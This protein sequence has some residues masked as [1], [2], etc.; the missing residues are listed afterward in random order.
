MCL[1]SCMYVHINVSLYLTYLPLT[2]LQNLYIIQRICAPAGT[3]RAQVHTEFFFCLGGSGKMILKISREIIA[4]NQNYCA[5]CLKIVLFWL[6]KRIILIDTN[7]YRIKIKFSSR[8]S[9]FAKGGDNI[10][11]H[12][13]TYGRYCK[14]ASEIVSYLVRWMR[15][16]I[17]IIARYSFSAFAVPRYWDTDILQLYSKLLRDS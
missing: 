5:I 11:L 15:N 10:S 9:Y 17:K 1:L 7:L 8:F 12:V 6:P 2:L 14:S 16:C 13:S 4:Q 3:I